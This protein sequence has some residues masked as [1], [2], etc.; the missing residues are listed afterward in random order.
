[1]ARRLG[2]GLSRELWLIEA[3]ILLNMLGYG[4]VLPFEVI[5]LHNGRGFSLGVAGLVAGAL[6]GVA[7][8]AA[9]LAG[10]L[11][12][13]FGARLTAVGAGVALAIGYAGLGFARTP[14]EAFAAA[15]LAGAG[16][17]GLNPSQSTLVATLTTADIRHR[18]TAI[19]RVATNA[20]IGIGGALGG[21]VAAYGLTGFVILFLAN[22]I[23]YLG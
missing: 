8:V 13:R 16:N 15:V 22:A 17:G 14:A 9:P 7:V 12:D 18:A 1:M 6:T 11:I 2:F 3:G 23:T 10:H 19:S 5:Y 20:G 4:A 21:L